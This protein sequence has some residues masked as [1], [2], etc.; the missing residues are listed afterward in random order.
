LV[1]G[2]IIKIQPNLVETKTTRKKGAQRAKKGKF[3][4][5]LPPEEMVR[6]RRNVNRKAICAGKASRNKLARTYHPDKHKSEVTGLTP[7][8]AKQYMQMINR[9]YEFLHE[10]FERG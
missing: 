10:Y 6:R 5:L 7:E 8:D 1:A 4:P 3:S 9:A 2:E